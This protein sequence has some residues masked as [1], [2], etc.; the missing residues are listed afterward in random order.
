MLNIW[1]TVK[2]LAR[3]SFAITLINLDRV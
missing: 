2:T 1:W 3:F